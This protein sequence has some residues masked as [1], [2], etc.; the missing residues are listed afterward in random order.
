MLPFLK[1]KKMS[2]MIIAKV[3]PKGETMPQGAEDE[4][5][6]GLVVAAEDLLAAIAS[7]DA[8]AV[9]EALRAAFQMC[10]MEPHVE[11]PHEDIGED[12]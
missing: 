9:A 8:N 5:N 11:G 6:M 1:P 10:D 12:D 3:S 2:S 7:K 4:E